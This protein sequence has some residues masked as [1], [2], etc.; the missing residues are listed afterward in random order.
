MK[1]IIS[2][3][4]IILLILNL[5]APFSAFASNEIV[6]YNCGEEVRLTNGLFES[7]GKIYT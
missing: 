1:T 2:K 5:I 3:V 4:M 6:L 7:N